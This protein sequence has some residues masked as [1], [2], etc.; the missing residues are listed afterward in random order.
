MIEDMPSDAT[1]GTPARLGIAR[2]APGDHR[3]DVTRLDDRR[4]A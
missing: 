2:A 4:I 1:A 3:G